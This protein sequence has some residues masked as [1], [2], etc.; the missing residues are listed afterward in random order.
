MNT[1][2]VVVASG[3]CATQ[4]AGAHLPGLPNLSGDIEYVGGVDC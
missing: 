2:P 3:V 4:P 1:D